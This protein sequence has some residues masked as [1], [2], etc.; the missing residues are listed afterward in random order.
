VIKRALA[1]AS[2]LLL[3]VLGAGHAQQGTSPAPAAP[4]QSMPGQV[5][6]PG[7]AQPSVQEAAP[8]GPG[9]GLQMPQQI[10]PRQAEMLQQLSPQ[11]Q[12]AIQEEVGKT[13][14]VLT[15]QAIEAL[16]SR[17]ELKG[18]TPED[19]AKGKAILEQTQKEAE[20]K[21]PEKKLLEERK[22]LEEM[23]ESRKTTVEGPEDKS[24]F[25]RFRTVQGY[26]DIS[27]AIRPFGYDFFREAAVK[28]LTERKDIPVPEK[29]VVGPGDEVK[30]LFWGRV[31]AQ[32]NLV[33]DRNG[34]ITIPNIG[35]VQV[36]GMTFQEMSQNLIKQSEQ[37][38]GANVDITMGS[39]KTIPVFILGDVRRPGAYTVGAF[40]TVTDALL[41][42]GGPTG[43]GSMRNVQLRRGDKIATT[44]DLY[45]LLLKG[46]KSRDMVL[47]AGDVVFVPVAG[48]LV[49]IAGN[50]KRPAIYELKGK[51]DLDTLFGLAGGI[52]PT[53]YTQQIQIDRVIKNEREIIVD[54]NDKELNKARNFVL[55]DADFIKVFNIVDRQANVVF[56][57]GNVK[58]PGKYEYKPGMRVKDLVK[59]VDDLLPETYLDY[60]L[61]K[62]LELPDLKASLVP[63]NLGRLISEGDDQ[64]N[65]ELK[66]QDSVYVFSKW[67]F[68]DKPFATIEGQVRNGGRFA[69][70]ENMRMKDL[71]LLAGDTTKDAYLQKGEIIRVN[72]KRG[73]VSVYFD[74]A[75]A[76]KGDP[77]ENV[78]IQD[79]DR[80]IIH[81]IWEERWRETVSIAGEVKQP[82]EFVLTEGM[83]VRDIVFRAGGITRDTYLKEAE[84]FRTDR[85]TKE[86]TLLKFDLDKALN[87]EK[88]DNIQLKDFDRVAVHSV[89][90][91]VYKKTVSIT[92]D[93]LKPGGYEYAEQMTVKDL[94]FTAG[95][96]LESAYLDQAEITSQ[97]VER[98]QTVRL[99]H[100]TINLKK[101]LQGEPADN[102]ALKPYDIVTVKRL[103]D[104][105]KE[106]FVSLTGEVLFPGSYMAKKGEN[107]SALIERAGGYTKEAYLRGAT[108][109]RGRVKEQQ[110]KSIAEMVVRLEKDLLAASTL[111]AS[112]AASPEELASQKAELEQRRK[113]IEILKK[114]EPTGRMTVRLAHLR[115]FKGSV[116][117]VPVEDGDS[118]FIPTRFAAVTVVGAVMAEGSYVFNDKWGYEDYI[119]MAGGYTH[120]ADEDRVF[121]LKVDGSARKL[122]KGVLS[123]NWGRERWEVAGFGEEE[124]PIDP[125]DSIVVPELLKRTP[126]LRNFKDITQI[127]ANVGLTAATIAILF[128][129]LNNND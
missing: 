6:A 48:S 24:L 65:V 124:R 98:G 115:L 105:R 106:R 47:Q 101:A 97:I 43:I 52:I 63:F 114:A 9:Q 107:L 60:A 36:A 14:G 79:E 83:T 86:V 109:T 69:L 93:V 10:T 34:N 75:K 77:A 72:K 12:Q 25:D 41:M 27:T 82:G 62:R 70:S 111:E 5:Q 29:Y 123:W 110:R 122:A 30:I 126:W 42:A 38:V 46:D 102:L 54:I 31:N 129:T 59:S 73:Y 40:A 81:S 49:G 57:N 53:A 44:F 20:K 56:L 11:Q 39:L 117:D 90:E 80:V 91:Y 18:I 113:F 1:I 21:E 89:W 119:Q 66:P 94:V 88:A 127:F 23:A 108:F 37:M 50:V 8:P 64:R 26:Q 96:V 32:H 104:W 116:Y 118:L 45:D 99:E 120:Y 33:V 58:R 112:T 78:L 85:K 121:A 15:P 84:L 61:I 2:I 67:F 128:D 87:G 71:I 22:P 92:G 125:G 95:N 4:P 74:V 7:S 3:L 76:L 17:P 68:T 13:G 35:P 100:K 55:Q 51:Q 16:K 103:Q 19:I 28:I